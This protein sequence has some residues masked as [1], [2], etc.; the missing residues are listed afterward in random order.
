MRAPVQRPTPPAAR[1]G[2]VVAAVAAG[3]AAGG[4]VAAARLA[5]LLEGAPALILLAG[6]TAALPVSRSFSRRVLWNG[7]LL[8]GVAPVLWW[9]PL[10]LGGLGRVGMVLAALSGGLTAWTM[11]RGP[12]AVRTRVRAL[13]PDLRPADAIPVLAGLVTSLVVAPWLRI[14]DPAVALSALGRGWDGSAHADMVE[15]IR[16]YGLT[17]ERMGAA[18]GGEAWQFAQYPEHFHTMV[19]MIVEAVHGATPG[20]AVTELATVARA[21]A[22]LLVT[23]TSMVAAG[24]A[25]L[26]RCRRRPELALP[27]AVI[28]VATLVIGAGGRAFVAGFP[29]FV[30]ATALTMCVVLVVAS[31]PRVTVAIAQAVLGALIVAIA[32]SW[33]LLLVVAVPAAVAGLKPWRGSRWHA[34]RRT[35]VVVAVIA[36]LTGAA[37]V[38]VLAVIGP[39]DAGAVLV[40]PGGIEVPSRRVTAAV[41]VLALAVA[42]WPGRH[43]RRTAWLATVPAAGV[44][45]AG[46][47]GLYQVTTAGSTSY[48]FHKLLLGAAL[49]C[50]VAIAAGLSYRLP[51]QRAAAGPG[52]IAT[53]VGVVA[54]TLVASQ[55]SGPTL[56]WTS[57]FRPAPELAPAARSVIAAAEVPVD[58]RRAVLV[59][60]PAL[61]MHPLNA[62]QWYL[63]LTGRWTT[64]T[65]IELTAVLLDGTGAPQEPVPSVV[66]ALAI[67][68]ELVVIT[69]PGTA[70]RA[71]PTLPEQDRRRIRTWSG[72]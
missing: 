60:D 1:R 48:Y 9:W 56:G 54:A 66:A 63:G 57:V 41:A 8:L 30:V 12:T 17:V 19:A 40:T 69:D 25:A 33:V 62:G 71:L 45:A 70:A 51:T 68:P 4:L 64:S 23:A 18:S 27:L 46:A 21:Q 38:R 58:A 35:S 34:D 50:L 13:V 53:V 59:L 26:P 37:T 65:N 39:L 36:S 14:A 10:P 5:G 22:L 61:G 52:R 72:D 2:A 3:L 7:S 47:L 42:L 11:W 29:N 20:P 43:L 31:M 67:D 16:S 15:M 28:P 6:L 49:L 24:V 44:A 32:H 55:L